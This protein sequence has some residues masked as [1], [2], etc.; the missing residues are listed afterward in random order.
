GNSDPG[1]LY[2]GMRLSTGNP[3][4]LDSGLS[5]WVG[6]TQGETN[7]FD[8]VDSAFVIAHR[9]DTTAKLALNDY[10]AE[11]MGKKA[12]DVF[13]L[14]SKLRSRTIPVHVVGMQCHWYVGPHNTGSSGAWDRQQ[15]AQN[16]ARIA[17]LG[18]DIS[19]TELDIRFQN[20]SDST[21]LYQQREAY[22][23]I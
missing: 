23:T 21:K 10:D 14:V 13:S 5:R 18:L 11:G 8:Y 1:N 6:Y 17:A 4:N 2:N 15:T 19:I 20:P 3:I 16:M 9:N 7:D 22:E 12:N